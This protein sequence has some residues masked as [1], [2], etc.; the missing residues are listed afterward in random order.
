MGKKTGPRIVYYIIVLIKQAIPRFAH[1]L[2]TSLLV[3]M[4]EQTHSKPTINKD[5][6]KNR[7]HTPLSFSPIILPYFPIQSLYF[8]SQSPLF[9][10]S[11][12][13]HFAVRSTY[14]V[15]SSPNRRFPYLTVVFP[16]PIAIVLLCN[17]RFPNPIT[18]RR[19]FP[20][21]ERH[22]PLSDR[23]ISQANC[24]TFLADHRI[25][26]AVGKAPPWNRCMK[27]YFFDVHGT[28]LRARISL[29][30]WH[31]PRIWLSLWFVILYFC[32]FFIYNSLVVCSTLLTL[33]G[34][35]T[36]QFYLIVYSLF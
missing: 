36:P 1:R 13:Y 6:R 4:N 9:S 15:F 33:N 11:D 5:Y 35:I 2:E 21:S 28:V 31:R 10:I 8:P 19:F 29:W 25:S 16:Y 30:N 3:R 17:R 32:F 12:H 23:R 24:R 22:F 14:A 34:L 20:Q 26:S 27:T 18:I 7:S